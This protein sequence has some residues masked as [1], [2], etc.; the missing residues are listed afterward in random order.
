[1]YIFFT[2]FYYKIFVTYERAYQLL[3]KINNKMDTSV[4]TGELELLPIP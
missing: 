3:H 1:M 4:S 2:L